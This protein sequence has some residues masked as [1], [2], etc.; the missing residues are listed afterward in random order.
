MKTLITVSRSHIRRGT[1]SADR[2]PLALAIRRVVQ[3]GRDIS[4]LPRCLSRTKVPGDVSISGTIIPLPKHANAF[5][6][7]FDKAVT[8]RSGRAHLKSFTFTL[9]IPRE[10]VRVRA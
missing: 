3:S 6:N 7:R 1:M 2:C 10:M 8:A 5:A 9:D 4:V